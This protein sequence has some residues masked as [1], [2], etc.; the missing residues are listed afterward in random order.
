MNA[1][2]DARSRT[3]KSLIGGFESRPRLSAVARFT[4]LSLVSAR[5]GV[6][7]A[8]RWIALIQ[9]LVLSASLQTICSGVYLRSFT[10]HPLSSN[11][12]HQTRIT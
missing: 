8:G 11:I 12:G 4:T 10:S 1:W 5:F 7:S 9:T 3:R 2:G 6:R